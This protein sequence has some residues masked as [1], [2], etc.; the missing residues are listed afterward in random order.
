MVLLEVT[1]IVSETLNYSVKENASDYRL[2]SA[3]IVLAM[4]N[5]GDGTVT[6]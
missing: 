1:V 4:L 6:L 2:E 5:Y 3:G